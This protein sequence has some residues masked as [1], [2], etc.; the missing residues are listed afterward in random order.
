MNQVFSADGTRRLRGAWLILALCFATTAVLVAASHWYLEKERHGAGS[1]A[2]RLQ[3]ARARVDGSRRERES[4]VQSEE[5][6]RALLAR[7]LMQS[8]RR[9]D[10]VELLNGLRARYQILGVD[11]EISPQRALPLPGGRSFPAVDILAS[12]VSLRVRALHEGDILA[13]IDSLGESRQGFYPVERCVLRRLE[14]S[15]PDLLQ[16]RVEADCALEWITMKEKR[17]A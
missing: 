11:Y 17:V 3:E 14:V 5:V 15:G 8:E 7:G 16:P 13:F 12:H 6:F 1:S 9:L 4:L 2:K 10:L